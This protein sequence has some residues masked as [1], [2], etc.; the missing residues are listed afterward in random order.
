MDILPVNDLPV[1]SEINPVNEFN[2]EFALIDAKDR[3][4]N[5]IKNAFI[6]STM[7]ISYKLKLNKNI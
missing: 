4:G 5:L 7:G 3:D 2:W 6:T 1:L